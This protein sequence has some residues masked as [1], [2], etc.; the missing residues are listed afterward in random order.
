MSIATL[1]VRRRVFSHLKKTHV[2][3]DDTPLFTEDPWRCLEGQDTWFIPWER[4][5]LSLQRGVWRRRTL[6]PSLTQCHSHRMMRH[7]QVIHPHLHHLWMTVVVRATLPLFRQLQRE[8]VNRLRQWFNL[9][10][11]PTVIFTIELSWLILC[12]VETAGLSASG[13]SNE[14]FRR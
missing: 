5:C 4:L 13:R 14:I 2:K 1:C 6:I 12:N 3:D 10:C 7:H 11:H 8:M 9:R